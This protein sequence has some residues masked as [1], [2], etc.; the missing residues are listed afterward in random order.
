MFTPNVPQFERKHWLISSQQ[1]RLEAMQ[2]GE[3]QLAASENRTPCEVRLLP[4]EYIPQSPEDGYIAGRHGFDPDSGKEFIELNPILIDNDEPY[5]AVHTLFHESRHAYQS[6]AIQDSTTQEDPEK[7]ASWKKNLDR[8]VYFQ[9]GTEQAP[10]LEDAYYRYQPVEADANQ[11]AQERM[12]T[13][14]Q[15]QLQDEQGYPQYRSNRMELDGSERLYASIVMDTDNPEEKAA[16]AVDQRY[17]Q[18][19]SQAE[20]NQNTL[21]QSGP[22]TEQPDEGTLQIIQ[23]NEHHECSAESENQVE[24][25]NQYYGIG[26]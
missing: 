22:A 14:Y 18:K 23:G 24:D 26:Y 16:Q 11:A 4:E 3:R 5:Q 19:Y 13:L 8:S 1:T 6:H 2:E 20:E 15:D 10:D 25:E 9:P 17:S 7:V 21:L 12:D